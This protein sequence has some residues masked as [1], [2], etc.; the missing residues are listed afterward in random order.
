MSRVALAHLIALMAPPQEGTDRPRRHHAR[1]RE[2]PAGSGADGIGAAARG[3]VDRALTHAWL[4]RRSRRVDAQLKRQLLAL[5]P[6]DVDLSAL[7]NGSRRF[8]RHRMPPEAEKQP[9]VALDDC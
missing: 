8:R 5:A 7:R 9:A 1:A 3:R 6:D 2:P 4:D